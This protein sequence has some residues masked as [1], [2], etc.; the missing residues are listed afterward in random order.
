MEIRMN[1][2][3]QTVI[4]FLACFLL[5][6]VVFAQS[7]PEKRLINGGIMGNVSFNHNIHDNAVDNC[8]K[9]HAIFAKKTGSIQELKNMQQLNKKHVMKNVCIS[10]HKKEKGTGPT[11]CNGCHQMIL[12]F[13]P[14]GCCLPF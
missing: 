7:N 12:N 5:P 8:Q 13:I 10:C 6:I 4:F 14:S 11:M 9:C 2:Y 1:N 3:S